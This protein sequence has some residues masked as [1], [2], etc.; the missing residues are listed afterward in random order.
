[1]AIVNFSLDT[2]TRQAVLIINGVL[3]SAKDIILEK[4]EFDGEELVRFS[5]MMESTNVDGMKERRQFFLPSPEE[6]AMVDHAGLNEQGLASKTV[7]D[8]NKAKADVINFFKR[9]KSSK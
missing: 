3:I 2:A 4:Y 9:D 6:L 5:Y 7:Y 8:D 1:M